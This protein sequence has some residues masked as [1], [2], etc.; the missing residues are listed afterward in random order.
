MNEGVYHG[1]LN[2]FLVDLAIIAETIKYT[3]PNVTNVAETMQFARKVL[4]AKYFLKSPAAPKRRLAIIAYGIYH[5][6]SGASSSLRSS[7]KSSRR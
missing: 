6:D 2:S 3:T 4:P 1:N 5:L 7:S